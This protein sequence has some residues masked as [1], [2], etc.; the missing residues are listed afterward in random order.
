MSFSA[1]SLKVKMSVGL[2]FGSECQSRRAGDGG[3]SRVFSDSDEDA[4]SYD[5]TGGSSLDALFAPPTAMEI[6]KV[7][8][9]SEA[10][11]PEIRSSETISRDKEPAWHT[12]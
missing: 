1:G 11:G 10:R 7:E 3:R 12:K 6:A 5:A 2:G 9:E 4:L 8:A